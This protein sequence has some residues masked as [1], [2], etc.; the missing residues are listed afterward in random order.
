MAYNIGYSSPDEVARLL[1]E[2]HDELVAESV[3]A[4]IQ[5]VNESRNQ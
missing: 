2:A 3:A 5:S 4:G 1:Q